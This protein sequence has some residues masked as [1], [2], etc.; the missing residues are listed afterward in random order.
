M[1]YE[2]ISYLYLIVCRFKEYKFIKIGRTTDLYRRVHNIKTG[3]PHEI[4]SVLIM[5]SEFEEEVIPMC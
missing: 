4:T 5:K 3:C 1:K 2:K